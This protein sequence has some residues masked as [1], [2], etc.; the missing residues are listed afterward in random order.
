LVQPGCLDLILRKRKGFVRVALESGADLVPVLGFGENE[1][2]HR[3]PLVPGSFA[4]KLQRV[5]K[6]V[7][8]G[9]VVLSLCYP[10][11]ALLPVGLCSL[12][13]YIWMT[14]TSACRFVVS[15]CHAAMGAAFWA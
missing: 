15:P 5:T 13:G 11:P 3:P 6:K 7:R 8:C 1:C 4:D 9:V 12:T 14:F 10:C 2:Y